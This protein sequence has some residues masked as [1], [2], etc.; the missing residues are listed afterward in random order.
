MRLAIIVPRYGEHILG[1]AETQARRFAEAMAQHG[2]EVEAWTTCAHSHYTW[3]NVYPQGS[4]WSHEVLVRRFPVTQGHQENWIKL[5]SKLSQTGTLTNLEAYEWLDSGVH[6]P[7]LYT[8]IAAH[9]SR[10]DAVIASPYAMPL[11]H[12]AAWSAID[13]VI[14]WPCLHDEPYA[15]LEPTR[16]LLENARGAMFYSPEEASLALN[17]L[18]I[19]PRR[20]A[21]LGGGVVLSKGNSLQPQ[22]VKLG[23]FLLYAGRLEEGKNL[24]LLYE[25][26]QRY[27]EQH[28]TIRLVVI[29]QGPLKPPRHPA[30]IYPGFVSEAEKA[31]LFHQAVAL[32]QPSLL[33]SFSLTIMEAWLAGRPVLVHQNCPV[34]QGHT[35]RSRG[36]LWF[37]TYEDF[38]GAVDW[39]LAHPEQ[40]A[41]MGRNGKQYVLANYTWEAVVKRFDKILR[42]WGNG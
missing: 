11:I 33:E 12:Y 31:A 5:E 18:G 32:C 41:Q 1:G 42:A 26:V 7:A 37:Q 16:L 29:G 9:A 14:L 22:T 15:Y 6:S 35:Q 2:W 27:F 39:L 20:H 40:A 25:Y 4:Y 10:F 8:H 36:G 19:R 21:V 38:A 28:R 17:R 24:S 13:Q 30:F 3:E 34:T 23:S